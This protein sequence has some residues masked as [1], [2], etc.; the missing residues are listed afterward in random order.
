MNISQIEL[1]KAF[2]YDENTGLFTRLYNTGGQT[3]Q[4]KVGTLN[5]KGYRLISYRNKQYRAH[6]LVFIYMGVKLISE[7]DHINHDKDDNRW[8]NLRTVNRN[9]NLEN[10]SKRTDNKSGV[11]GVSYCSIR[12]KWV[13]YINY[14]KKRISLGRFK[15]KQEAIKVR[16][17]ANKQYG[18]HANHGS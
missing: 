2:S 18:F 4:D 12:N 11:V 15:T 16:A 10:Q 3:T 5:D 17:Q 1:K 7:V 14:N 13:S 8:C 9:A 6:R